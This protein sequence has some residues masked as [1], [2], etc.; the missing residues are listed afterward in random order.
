MKNVIAALVVLALIAPAVSAAML[1]EATYGCGDPVDFGKAKQ[2]ADVGTT[3]QERPARLKIE[4][5]QRSVV[6]MNALRRRS[7]RPGAAASGRTPP[8]T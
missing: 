5:E 8:A 4:L 7:P 3:T 1:T 2:D 6:D